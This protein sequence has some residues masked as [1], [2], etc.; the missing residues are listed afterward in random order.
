M[1][2]LIAKNILFLSVLVVLGVVIGCPLYR[3]TG[4]KCPMCGMT[5]AHLS[6]IKGDIKQAFEFHSLFFLGVPTCLGFLNLNDV[7]VKSFKLY[8]I[9][10]IF[11]VASVLAL[12][13]RFFFN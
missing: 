10:V 7:K 12:I 2:K 6:F 3:I 13:A 5:R 9:I 8:V 1:K 4:I 11:L